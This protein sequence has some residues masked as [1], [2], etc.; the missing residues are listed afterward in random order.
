M[1][2]LKAFWEPTYNIKWVTQSDSRPDSGPHVSRC[3][4]MVGYC[5]IIQIIRG[6]SL[7]SPSLL[8]TIGIV[9]IY[10]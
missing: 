2:R 1:P 6:S 8:C 9:L 3:G 7:F 5:V 10:Y 4:K